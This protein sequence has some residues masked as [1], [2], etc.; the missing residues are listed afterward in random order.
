ML[1]RQKIET[2]KKGGATFNPA[3]LPK[4]STLSV[5]GEV[6]DGYIKHYLIPGKVFVAREPHA[7][8]TILGSGVAICVW[9]P[10]TGIGGA[11]HFLLPEGSAS[12]ANA[13]RYASYANEKLLS[14][15]SALGVDITKLQ[16]KIFGGSQPA[17]SFGNSTETLGDRNV[18]TAEQFLAAKGIALKD[19]QVGGTRG[20]KLIFCSNNGAVW[21]QQF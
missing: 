14:D 11:N 18:Q 2:V 6:P 3:V 4:E 20:R 7:I 5:S 8:T 9:D 13:T 21:S 16:A 12:E 15:I 17:I 19:R 10:A 1:F